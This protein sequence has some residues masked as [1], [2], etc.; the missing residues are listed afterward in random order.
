MNAQLAY[1]IAEACAVARAGRTS[2]YAAI[3]SGELVARK[4][5]RRTVILADD[6]RR[7]LECLPAVTPKTHP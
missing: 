6:L 3:K 1:S 7:W 4:R 5:G 2:V